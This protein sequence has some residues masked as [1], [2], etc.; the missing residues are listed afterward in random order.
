MGQS[1]P[2]MPWDWRRGDRTSQSSPLLA[3]V[4]SSS[5]GQF[6]TCVS[7]NYNCGDFGTQAEAQRILDEYPGDPHRLD[8][9]G[10]GE[11]CESL[12]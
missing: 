4:Q 10:D 5:D 8:S 6:P 12:P 11:A 1:D 3:P 2:M 7:S 9:D